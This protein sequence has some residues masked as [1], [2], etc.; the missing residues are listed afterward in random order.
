MLSRGKELWSLSKNLNKSSSMLLLPLLGDVWLAGSSIYLCW[1]TDLGIKLWLMSVQADFQCRRSI[2]D[3]VI[4]FCCSF[5]GI[6]IYIVP[7]VYGIIQLG[8]PWAKEVMLT[9]PASFWNWH[10][11]CSLDTRPL[12]KT[13]KQKPWA[14]HELSI[15][16]GMHITYVPVIIVF[17]FL[18]WCLQIQSSLKTGCCCVLPR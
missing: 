6:W 8:L 15:F 11:H 2:P 13:N 18:W 4:M 3:L 1:R 7:A 16:L 14:D 9:S 5:F 17:H 12:A 10:F